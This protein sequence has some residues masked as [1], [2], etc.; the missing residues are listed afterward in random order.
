MYLGNFALEMQHWWLES[1]SSA[2]DGA[3]SLLAWLGLVRRSIDDIV[4]GKDW[5]HAFEHTGVLSGQVNM[6]SKSLKAFGWESPPCVGDGLPG[7]GQSCRYVFHVVQVPMLRLGSIGDQRQNTHPSKH[8]TD[9]C[10]ASE[11]VN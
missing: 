4:L 10:N 11:A 3:V 6:S 1:K 2:S 9:R 7:L 8:W 5:H